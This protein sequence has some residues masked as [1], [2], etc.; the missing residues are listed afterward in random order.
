MISNKSYHVITLVMCN[1]QAWKGG[2]AFL[3][4]VDKLVNTSVSIGEDKIL[5]L[6]LI[7]KN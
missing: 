4:T 5:L 2:N 3:L 6:D 7:F 1:F